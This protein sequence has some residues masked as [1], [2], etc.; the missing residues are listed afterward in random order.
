M[1]TERV[2]NTGGGAAIYV[3]PRDSGGLLIAQGSSYLLF[4]A[5]ELAEL[6]AIINGAKL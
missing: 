1:T 4:N 5:E 6:A 2:I 3:V